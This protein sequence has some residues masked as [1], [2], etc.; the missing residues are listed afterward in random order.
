MY[1]KKEEQYLEEKEKIYKEREEIK[2][3]KKKYGEKNKQI[4]KKS[5]EILQTQLNNEKQKY[6]FYLFCFHTVTNV[7]NFYKFG[8]KIVI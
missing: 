1:H 4:L 2:K 5:E 6:S 7:F 3:N 8:E